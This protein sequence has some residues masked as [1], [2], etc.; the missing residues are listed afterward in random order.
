MNVL[1]KPPTSRDWA[2]Y[3]NSCTIWF[4]YL[5]MSFGILAAKKLKNQF[6]WKK[7][8]ICFHTV[9]WSCISSSIF[10]REWT[11]T[12]CNG[13]ENF[14]EVHFYFFFNLQMLFPENILPNVLS[15]YKKKSLCFHFA[16]WLQKRDRSWFFLSN[17]L[18]GG[19]KYFQK[20]GF[21]NW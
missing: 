1:T 14:L 15:L 8:A 20:T 9:Y 5:S 4:T 7:Q 12:V 3:V 13:L 6:T 11:N 21:P 17:C 2:C 19:G 10:I 18:N 16:L